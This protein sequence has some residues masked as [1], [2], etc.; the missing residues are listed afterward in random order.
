MKFCLLHW[1]LHTLSQYES[2]TIFHA[3]H[4]QYIFRTDPLSSGGCVHARRYR[5]SF[6]RSASLDHP[7]AILDCSFVPEL[8]CGITSLCCVRMCL[9][10][11]GG[12]L[13][14]HM[15]RSLLLEVC[16]HRCGSV[17]SCWCVLCL[18]LMFGA[19]PFVM[20][21]LSACICVYVWYFVYRGSL[22]GLLRNIYKCC[23]LISATP[24][25]MDD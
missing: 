6:W 13:S 7:S 14:R 23:C 17:C 9:F 25:E 5:R 20:A 15:I 3:L 2:I 8:A 10:G 1:V 16:G 12:A 21:A 18:W 19:Y 22:V 4:A 24:W 11:Y